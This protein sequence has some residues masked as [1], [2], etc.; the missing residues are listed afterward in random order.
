V[1]CQR[2][3]AFQGL[4]MLGLNRCDEFERDEILHSVKEDLLDVF[5][6]LR[7]KSKPSGWN[8]YSARLET[9]QPK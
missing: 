8:M 9:L 5:A 7:E 6:T 3:D 4:I 1:S 2:M